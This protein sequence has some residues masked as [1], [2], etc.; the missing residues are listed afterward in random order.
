VDI[1]LTL[2]QLGGRWIEVAPPGGGTS[3]ALVP[4]EVELP[5]VEVEGRHADARFDAYPDCSLAEWHTRRGL[6]SPPDRGEKAG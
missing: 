1:G 3:V 2:P 4:A 6:T 5:W